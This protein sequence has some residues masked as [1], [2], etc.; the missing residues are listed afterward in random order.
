MNK[1]KALWKKSKKIILRGNSLFS[2]NLKIIQKIGQYILKKLK[3]VI[4]GQ[5]TKKNLS[6]FH[7]WVLE[8]IF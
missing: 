4:Y 8:Q 1:N 7:I 6:I 3:D 2:K 5:S